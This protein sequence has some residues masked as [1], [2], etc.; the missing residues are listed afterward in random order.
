MRGILVESLVLVICG[1]CG[2]GASEPGDFL[3]FVLASA[4]TVEA[5]DDDVDDSRTVDNV[6][7]CRL[8]L[9]SGVLCRVTGGRLCRGLI[10]FVRMDV[11]ESEVPGEYEDIDVGVDDVLKAPGDS[12]YRVD[13]VTDNAYCGVGTGRMSVGPI[14]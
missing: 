5:D 3:S 10:C 2:R 8:L 7:G 14:S 11:R 9:S 4:T 6:C 13:G 1:L 12:E